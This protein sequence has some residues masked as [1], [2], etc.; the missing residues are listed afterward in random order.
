MEAL[1]HVAQIAS[2][3][4]PAELFIPIRVLIVL[5][6]FIVVHAQ[7]RGWRE[8]NFCR[9]ITVLGYFLIA[10]GFLFSAILTGRT[11]SNTP[12][13]QSLI[14]VG[15]LLRLSAD[16]ISAGHR[17]NVRRLREGRIGH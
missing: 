15:V 8:M 11:G 1:D 3:A 13:Y 4:M 6:C 9:R 16:A 7:L 5:A 10:A 17:R 12:A 2:A 14:Q